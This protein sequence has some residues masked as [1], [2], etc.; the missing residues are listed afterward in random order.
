MGPK[1]FLVFFYKFS[2]QGVEQKLWVFFR[3]FSR[4]CQHWVT[5][6]RK[7]V[8]PANR[9]DCTQSHLLRNFEERFQRNERRSN[10]LARDRLQGSGKWLLDSRLTFPLT[11]LVV[12]SLGLSVCHNFLKERKLTSILFTIKICTMYRNEF[13]YNVQVFFEQQKNHQ[14]VLR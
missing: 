14:F 3:E 2:P 4:T 10:M 1:N 8:A 6:G 13:H 11:L 5:I 12:W 9:S 7:K